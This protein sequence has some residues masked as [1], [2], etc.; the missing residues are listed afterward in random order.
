MVE[1]RNE[2]EEIAQKCSDSPDKTERE[3]Q[4]IKQCGLKEFRHTAP[5][6]EWVD[7]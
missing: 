7:R 4:S 6:G 2:P 3:Q 1:S 5:K